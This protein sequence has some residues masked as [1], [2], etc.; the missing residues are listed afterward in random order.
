[1]SLNHKSRYHVTHAKYLSPEILKKMPSLPI[2]DWEKIRVK[3][4]QME[5]AKQSKEEPLPKAD[6]VII[7]WTKAEWA[8]LDHVFCDSQTTMSFV[9]NENDSWQ[10]NWNLYARGYEDIES[11]LPSQGVPSKAD[12][13]WG[14]FR[15]V[16]IGNHKVLLFKSDMHITTDGPKIPLQVLIRRIIQEKNIQKK[17]HGQ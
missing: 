17:K 2:V 12:K 10:E 13:S 8:A 14:R 1:M 16:L 11:E 5:N 7:T 9:L 4:P 15:I 6:V 3:A